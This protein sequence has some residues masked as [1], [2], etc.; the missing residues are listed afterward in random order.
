MNLYLLNNLEFPTNECN[1]L[2]NLD[3]SA[4]KGGNSFVITRQINKYTMKM[5]AQNALF[6]DF[7]ILSITTL[8][9]L[10]LMDYK[11]EI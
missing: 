4:R 5:F 6:A 10:F 3:Q 9:M 8:I 7:S 11:Q 1:Y 2:I